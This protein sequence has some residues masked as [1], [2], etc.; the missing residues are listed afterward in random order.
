MTKVGEV[1][2]QL[3]TPALC[4]MK[5]KYHTLSGFASP[6]KLYN[7]DEQNQPLGT[8]SFHTLISAS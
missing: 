5:K 2:E 8:T 4:L 6:A 1:L 7:N 3:K